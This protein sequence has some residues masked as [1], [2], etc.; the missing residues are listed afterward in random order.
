MILTM[1]AFFAGLILYDDGDP[2]RPLG[3]SGVFPL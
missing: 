1:T 3:E 2:G